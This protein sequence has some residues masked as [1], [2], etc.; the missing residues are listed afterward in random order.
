MLLDVQENTIDDDVESGLFE[1]SFISD[2]GSAEYETFDNEEDAWLYAETL[3]S[4]HGLS[5]SEKATVLVQNTLH[6]ENGWIGF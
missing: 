2:D 5:D 4:L 1:V 6:V 3:L